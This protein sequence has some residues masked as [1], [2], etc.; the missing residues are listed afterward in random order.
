MD[1]RHH[2][3]EA[4]SEPA[5]APPP[6]PVGAADSDPPEPAR[7]DAAR[8]PGSETAPDARGRLERWLARPSAPAWI[9]SLAAL[10]VLPSVTCGLLADDY[11]HALILRGSNEIPAFARSKLDIFR[12]TT[13]AEN[14]S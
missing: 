11:I 14:P 8:A 2:S 12:F 3:E 9:V 6:E 7:A 13:P 10:L 4:P 1:S 5:C